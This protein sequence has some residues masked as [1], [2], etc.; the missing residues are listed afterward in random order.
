MPPQGRVSDLAMA[1]ADAHGCLA[2]PHP[3]TGPGKQGSPDVKVN[4]LPALRVGDPG[5]HAPCC[6]GNTWEAQMGSQTVF[7]NGKAAHRMGDATRHCG[8]VGT[9]VKGSPDVFVGG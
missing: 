9:L 6:G 2:C 3:V 8:G 5:M 1:P 7:I 4:G